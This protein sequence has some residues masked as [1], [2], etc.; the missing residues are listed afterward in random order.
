MTS[1]G[2]LLEN[3]ADVA[4]VNYDGELPVDIA[5]SHDAMEELLQKA[6]EEKGVDCN[7]CRN[8][9]VDALMSDAKNW[10]V[11]GY[12]EVRDPKTG[13]TPLHVAAAKGYI[14]V[15]EMLLE[16]CNVEPDCVDYEGWTPL[17][18][19]ALWGQKDAAALLL[20]Y[21]A[22]PNLKN[23][24]G[25]T[26][27]D[28]VDPS[29]STWLAEAS[30]KASR[31]VNNNNNNNNNKRKRSPP[32]HD[33]KRV[34]LQI[35]GQTDNIVNDKPPAA[36]EII[37]KMADGRPPKGRASSPEAAGG[38]D[39]P[40]APDESPSWRRSASFRKLA[41]SNRE[42]K[43]ANNMDNDTI[44]RRTHSFENDKTISPTER[45]DKDANSWNTPATTSVNSTPTNT[46]TQTTVR[47]SFVPPVRDE[48]SETQR[49]A[50]AKRVRETRRS[51]QGVTLDEI[52]SAEQL[53][54]KKT[55]NGTAEPPAAVKKTDDAPSNTETSSARVQAGG[56]AAAVTL[57]LASASATATAT[58]AA[59]SE[60]RP[61]WRLRLDPT[62]K[63]HRPADPTHRAPVV[64]PST[65]RT[66]KALFTPDAAAATA[67][68]VRIGTS[69]LC[70]PPS[71][72]T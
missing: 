31:R 44:L 7:K 67:G 33:V 28:L 36:P 56:G 23:Y 10:A 27:M 4:A 55:G 43:P 68:R 59:N 71:W 54:K 9:E 26:C 22:D 13:G 61:S 64:W 20:K 32:R 30:L 48:E 45:R 47:R 34:E 21:G 8:A 57:A 3:G 38:A 50:H 14:E 15:A 37:T 46:T 62:N 70:R 53:V 60:R 12:V 63:V 69:Q 40:P 5:E 2:Y 19:A 51:T 11:N 66:R 6:I 1:S 35:T 16:E 42:N 29:I 65:R 41:D 52:K 39:T 49:K 72:S 18:A 17:H 25:Q 24:S 58:I